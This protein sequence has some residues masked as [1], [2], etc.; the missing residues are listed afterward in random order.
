MQES[1]RRRSKVRFKELFPLLSCSSAMPT[2]S[3]EGACLNHDVGE[4]VEQR[5]II[6]V[7][8]LRHQQ[9]DSFTSGLPTEDRQK[10]GEDNVGRLVKSM[11]G[12]QYASHIWQFDHVNLIC[13]ELGGFRRGKHSAALFHNPNEDVWMAVH[14]DDFVCLSD[15]VGLKHIDCLP[16]SQHTGE[17]HGKTGIRRFRREKPSVV[18]SCV[19]SWS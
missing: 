13:G 10:Y 1:T 11:Y 18:E 15:D 6:E 14:G 16:K 17:R 4:L 12:T 9:S 8:T 5:D 19:Q 2:G 3:C 7:E